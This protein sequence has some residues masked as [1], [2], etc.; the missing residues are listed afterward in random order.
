V[1]ASSAVAAS[2]VALA[3]VASC[4]DFRGQLTPVPPVHRVPPDVSGA[5][6]LIDRDPVI[7]TRDPGHVTRAN[8]QRVPQGYR[9]ALTEALGLAGFRVV[10]RADEPH[11]LVAKLAIAVEEQRDHVRQV[12]RCGL[13]GVDGTPVVQIDWTW[14]HGTYVRPSEVYQFATH[15]VATAAATSERLHTYLR[16]RRVDGGGG[17]PG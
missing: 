7:E 12:Y 8:D 11:D 13:T 17:G 1:R 4:N 6:V 3:G 10:A 5:V 15:N 14:P 16:G 2:F 9:E